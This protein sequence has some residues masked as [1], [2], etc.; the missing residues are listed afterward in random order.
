MAVS[1]IVGNAKTSLQFSI[2][3]F[4]EAQEINLWGNLQGSKCDG[5]CIFSWELFSFHEKF[6]PFVPLYVFLELFSL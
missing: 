5:D 2:I 6:L 3:V 4:V 1:T